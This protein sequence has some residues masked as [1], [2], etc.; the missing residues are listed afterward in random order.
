MRK[1]R[2]HEVFR[3]TGA[4]T[5]LTEDVRQRQRRYIISMSIRTV[6]VILTVLLWN[7]ERPLAWVMLVAG[8]LLPYVAVVAAN[9]GRENAPRQLDPY[10]PPPDRPELGPGP[11]RPEPW[12]RR[13]QW[14]H[15]QE[16]VTEP[17]DDRQEPS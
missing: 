7:V 12:E 1:Q 16:R 17:P 14:E 5:G 2:E 9:A 11:E 13:D 6:S 10:L 15:P 3:I 8:A 4:R